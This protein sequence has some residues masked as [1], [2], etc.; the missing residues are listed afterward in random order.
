MWVKGKQLLEDRGDWRI[1]RS[2]GGSRFECHNERY[3][4]AD[5]TAVGVDVSSKDYEVA[6]DV[7]NDKLFL[8]RIPFSDM[9][10]FCDP[11]NPDTVGRVLKAFGLFQV[12]ATHVER[13]HRIVL[14]A[15][16]YSLVMFA[17]SVSAVDD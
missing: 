10:T 6:F 15:T 9:D 8:K 4:D 3:P 5:D 12:S 11:S 7:E 13:R 14:I 16:F 2:S 17:N 1:Y